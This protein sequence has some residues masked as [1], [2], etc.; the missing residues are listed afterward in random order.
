VWAQTTFSASG[1]NAADIQTAVDTFRAALGGGTTPGAA[2]SF[3][4]VRREINWDAV[5]DGSS[6][7]NNLPAN[8]FNANSP[9]GAVFSSPSNV[10]QVSADAS[11]PTS[12]PTDFANLDASY[13]G[14]F[15]AFSAERL[16]TAVGSNIVEVT[17]FVAGTNTPGVVRGFG[18]V[19][20]DV[21]LANT[22]SLQFFDINN[23]SLGTFFVP[24]APGNETFSFLGVTFTGA[25]VNRVRITSGNVAPGPGAVETAV[26]DVVVMDDFIYAEPTAAAPEPN[27]ASLAAVAC[28]SF[29]AF[30][31]VTR[32]RRRK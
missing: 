16:F 22:T 10:F 21:D 32:R 14:L 20:A 28:G 19:F 15:R 26:N 27:S 4:G 1:A 12:T 29:G 8:F 9:R 23:T 30:W 31:G 2:G 13:A 7:P 17:F 18:S 5:L 24:N 25:V 3:G 11:N 6:A